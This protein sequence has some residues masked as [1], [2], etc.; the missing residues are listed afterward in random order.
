MI[1]QL[2]KTSNRHGR[3]SHDDLVTHE[4]WVVF[5]VSIPDHRPRRKPVFKN[6]FELDDFFG[7]NITDDNKSP[8]K[9]S[10][11]RSQNEIVNVLHKLFLKY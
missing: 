8:Q 11:M 2:T 6:G 1:V 7:K 9:W 10:H 3:S 5:E 4:P